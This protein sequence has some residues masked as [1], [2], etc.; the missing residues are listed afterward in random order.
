M[1]QPTQEELWALS[2]L[3]QSAQ[4]V[5]AEMQ[6]VLAARKAYIELLETKY[7]VKFDEITGQFTPIVKPDVPT[8]KTK[9]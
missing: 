1:E 5:N 8:Q 2:I 7:T 6:R 4:N 9:E 3:T